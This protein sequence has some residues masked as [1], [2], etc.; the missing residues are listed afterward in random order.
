MFL[1]LSKLYVAVNVAFP[2]ESHFGIRKSP[3][4]KCDHEKQY[5][6]I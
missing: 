2:F 6:Y 3:M 5:L 4:L 1:H